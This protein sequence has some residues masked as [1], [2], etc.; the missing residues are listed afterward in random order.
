MPTHA[1]HAAGLMRGAAGPVLP[2]RRLADL[3]G[4]QPA[5]LAAELER[6]PRF[7]VVRRDPVLDQAALRT[8]GFAP[9][10]APFF[11]AAGLTPSCTIVLADMA[12]NDDSAA[13]LLART[14]GCLLDLTAA[15]GSRGAHSGAVEAAAALAPLMLPAG[16]S[17]T[18]LPPSPPTDS[19]P[20]RRR[21]PSWRPPHAP[22]CRRG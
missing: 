9:A 1:D 8:D 12:G 7:R 19:A 2:L 3:L 20:P 22:G 17:T 16:T 6:D 15:A 5:A 14:L 10:Y 4:A 13:A 21:R 11:E 18:P